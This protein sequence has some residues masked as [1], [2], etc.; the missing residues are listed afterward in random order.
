MFATSSY[1]NEVVRELFGRGGLNSPIVASSP[2][3]DLPPKRLTLSGK[4]ME[5][6]YH[7][8]TLLIWLKVTKQILGTSSTANS[9][10]IAIAS[11]RP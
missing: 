9:N 1:V 2:R 5:D 7:S 3:L 8:N 4:Y 10:S 6:S 11:R